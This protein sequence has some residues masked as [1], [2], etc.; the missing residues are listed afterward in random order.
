MPEGILNELPSAHVARLFLHPDDLFCI[1][2]LIENGFKIGVMHWVQ[3]F[4]S[5]DGDIVSFSFAHLVNEV[6]VDLARAEEHSV[7]FSS[8]VDM[9]VIEDMAESSGFEF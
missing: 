1:A 5:Y 8:V 2:V 3:L 9:T 6:V 7:D 4:D